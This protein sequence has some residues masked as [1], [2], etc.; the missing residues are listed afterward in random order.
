[1]SN[2]SPS[3]SEL[4]LADTISK[5]ESMGGIHAEYAQVLRDVAK[6]LLYMRDRAAEIVDSG[7]TKDE[8]L[9]LV[10]CESHLAT[11]PIVEFQAI[12]LKLADMATEVQAARLLTWWAASL[13]DSGRRADRD[14]RFRGGVRQESNRKSD[15]RGRRVV[16]PRHAR[17]PRQGRA[18]SP[19]RPWASRWKHAKPNFRNFEAV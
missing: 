18:T 6:R 10:F 7:G 17:P 14:R 16:R 4:R 15:R 3:P 9:V 19:C 12:Q 8:L 13:L 2:T 11:L 1:M 5:L